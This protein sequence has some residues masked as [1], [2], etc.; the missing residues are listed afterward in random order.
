VTLT[1]GYRII[2][3]A[4]SSLLCEKHHVRRLDR[5]LGETR[6]CEISRCVVPETCQVLHRVS[7]GTTWFL[8]ALCVAATVG[9]RR[10]SQN[11]IINLVILVLI[12]GRLLILVLI[13]LVQNT[14]LRV[15]GQTTV[16]LVRLGNLNCLYV[17]RVL[18]TSFNDHLIV[19]A[20]LLDLLYILLV[21]T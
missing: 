21:G 10:L 15:P 6:H 14:L 13:D 11:N 18:R 20:I 9:C 1:L 2:S 3:L 5:C 16:L 17:V 4:A 8:L 7:R 12:Q 19:G